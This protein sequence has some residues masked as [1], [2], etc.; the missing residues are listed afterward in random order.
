MVLFDLSEYEYG[1]SKAEQRI[2]VSLQS[3]FDLALQEVKRIEHSRCGVAESNC[4]VLE[5]QE[6]LC[7]KITQLRSADQT[8]KSTSGPNTGVLS[9]THG[10]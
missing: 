10:P 3:Q 9:R 8:G 5:C 4:C 7:Y 1:G 2:Q 6:N